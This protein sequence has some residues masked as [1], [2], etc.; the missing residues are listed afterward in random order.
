MIS[1]GGERVGGAGGF[2]DDG[3]DASPSVHQRSHDRSALGAVIDEQHPPAA[4][5]TILG[6]IDHQAHRRGRRN[7]RRGPMR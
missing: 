3:P 4:P 7:G 1:A 5:D 2:G 6:R